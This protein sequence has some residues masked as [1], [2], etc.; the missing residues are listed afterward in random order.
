MR[1]AL[2]GWLDSLYSQPVICSVIGAHHHDRLTRYR[3]MWDFDPH[4]GTEYR[5]YTGLGVQQDRG[6]LEWFRYRAAADVSSLPLTNARSV[7]E[8]SP[9]VGPRMQWHSDGRAIWELADANGENIGVIG[10]TR[11]LALR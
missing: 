6:V 5:A 4:A 1:A 2:A 10:C 8:R 11:T 7:A 3:P 9:H